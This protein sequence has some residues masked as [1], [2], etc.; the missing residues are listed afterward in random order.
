[1]DLRRLDHQLQLSARLQ[2]PLRPPHQVWSAEPVD[3]RLHHR[4]SHALAAKPRLETEYGRRRG[5]KG[6]ELRIDRGRVREEERLDGKYLLTTTDPSLSAE[7]VALGYK[8]LLEVEQRLALDAAHLEQR[9][10]A[11]REVAKLGELAGGEQ[12]VG[13]VEAGEGGIMAATER[14]ERGP[15]RHRQRLSR[16]SV[17]VRS[18]E[19]VELRESLTHPS[20]GRMP[21]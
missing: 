1:L 21:S 17:G 4:Q 2:P 13:D 19:L 10:Q 8:Q 15:A 20:P 11:R 7:D 12:G 9:R 16:Q 14:Q 6:G 18:G 5:L 3:A